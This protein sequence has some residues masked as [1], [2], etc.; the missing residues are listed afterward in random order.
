MNHWAHS[1]PPDR[2][3]TSVTCDLWL[4]AQLLWYYWD[5]GQ[6][7][8]KRDNKDIKW[9]MKKQ[10]P[11]S[12]CW[13][14]K[15]LRVGGSSPRMFRWLEMI[16]R[17]LK[18]CKSDSKDHKCIYSHSNCF[19]FLSLKWKILLSKI[20]ICIPQPQFQKCWNTV[21]FKYQNVQT[22][23]FYDFV[24]NHSSFW[25]WWQQYIW[26]L[27]RGA[28]KSCKSEWH[29]KETAGGTFYK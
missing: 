9:K 23:T 13:S 1:A 22:E 27:G 14:S 19:L 3:T 25:M 18:V 17:W 20:L 8:H 16:V 7:L 29:K 21:T 5:R 24:I 11:S 6:K 2:T 4:F 15:I 12:E 26:Q 10:Y 28:T